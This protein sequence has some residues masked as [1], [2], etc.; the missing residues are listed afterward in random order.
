MT[1]HHGGMPMDTAAEWTTATGKNNKKRNHET[2]PSGTSKKSNKNEAEE[3]EIELIRTIEP[4][5]EKTFKTRINFTIVPQRGTTKIS[6]AHIM[7]R[8]ITS[9]KPADA[10]ARFVSEDTN[11]NE[12]EYNGNKA[13]PND[14]S[15]VQ[16]IAHQ[17]LQGL[18]LTKK[19]NTLVGMMILRSEIEFKAIMKNMMVL[20]GL[21]EEPKIFFRQNKIDTIN[22]TL[23]GFFTNES[24][25]AD[26][27]E[28]FKERLKQVTSTNS[29]CPSI[30][31]NIAT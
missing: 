22:P 29:N 5:H 6:I 1:N 26:K 25:R 31:L 30:K 2:I 19:R 28:V 17:Y 7:W 11:G 21:N 10:K 20:Q 14:P 9:L 16:E 3:N 24:P 12:K 4:K 27:P 18:M 13:L 23:V 8:L 15:A